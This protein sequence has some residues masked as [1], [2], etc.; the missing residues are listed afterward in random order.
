MLCCPSI[1]GL[2]QISVSVTYSLFHTSLQFCLSYTTPPDEASTNATLKEE[3][4][5]STDT[6]GGLPSPARGMP[7]VLDCILGCPQPG[8]SCLPS[9]I[10]RYSLK[11]SL[12]SATLV[13]SLSPECASMHVINSIGNDLPPW[14]ILYHQTSYFSVDPS[15]ED[16]YILRGSFPFWTHN[17]NMHFLL[18]NIAFLYCFIVLQCVITHLRLMVSRYQGLCHFQDTADVLHDVGAQ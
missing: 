4:L 2:L 3:V 14:S 1:P 12:P 8:S 7:A 10:V 17:S 18:N 15:C 11:H 13:Y 5:C 16:V 6:F 9:L